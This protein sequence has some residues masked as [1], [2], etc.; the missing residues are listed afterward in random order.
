[1]PSACLPGNHEVEFYFQ[2]HMPVALPTNP[3]DPPAT[4]PPPLLLEA[5]SVAPRPAEAGDEIYKLVRDLLIVY[6]V[7]KSGTVPGTPTARALHSCYSDAIRDTTNIL[8]T[9]KNVEGSI[10]RMHSIA[11]RRGSFEFGSALLQRLVPRNHAHICTLRSFRASC[12]IFLDVAESMVDDDSSQQQR[13]L[14]CLIHELGPATALV[15]TLVCE[16][17]ECLYRLEGFE[18]VDTFF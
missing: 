17:L 1:M 6:D 16:K 14:L 11:R 8:S 7:S 18:G 4:R 2:T 12:A 10:E 9:L 15:E 3:N 13:E 5:W